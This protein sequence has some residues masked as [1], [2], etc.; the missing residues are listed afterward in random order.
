[1]L[2]VFL[3]SALPGARKMDDA[4]VDIKKARQHF[5]EIKGVTRGGP[6]V[7]DRFD[8]LFVAR[9]FNHRIDEAWPVGTE[10]PGNSRYQVPIACLK[11]EFF[12]G[13]FRFTISA[14]WIGG[15]LFR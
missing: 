5:G 3:P 10:N 11:H 15:V 13:T 14:N 6:F 12:T 2:G 7:G 4:R 8:F 9:P 1:M